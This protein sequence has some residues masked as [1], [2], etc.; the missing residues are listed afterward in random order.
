[1]SGA[2]RGLAR[3]WHNNR[4]SIPEDVGRCV[5]PVSKSPQATGSPLAAPKRVLTHPDLPQIQGQGLYEYPFN[6]H[7]TR[8]FIL[9]PAIRV[10]A[11]MQRTLGTN[12]LAQQLGKEED[13]LISEIWLGGGREVSTLTEMARVFH[14]M[15]TTPLSAGSLFGWEPLDVGETR[16]LVKIVNVIIGSPRT[17]YVEVREFIEQRDPSYLTQSLELILK[18]ESPVLPPSGSIVMEGL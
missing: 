6:P 3:A 14:T 12:I 18:T 4:Q 15:W 2:L 8:G 11:A 9:A 17:E 1:M 7:I 5:D 10:D 16:Y 13:V